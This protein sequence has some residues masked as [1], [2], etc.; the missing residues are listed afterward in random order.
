MGSAPASPGFA[1]GSHLYL[2]CSS[3]QASGL[4]P[5]NVTTAFDSHT[6]G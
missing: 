1:P 5:R 4:E 3:G 2:A 6:L